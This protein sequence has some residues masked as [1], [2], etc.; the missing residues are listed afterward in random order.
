MAKENP[1]K[2]GKMNLLGIIVT[3]FVIGLLLIAA[4]YVF[5]GGIAGTTILT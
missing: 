5:V 2:T 1:L 3:G 4:A